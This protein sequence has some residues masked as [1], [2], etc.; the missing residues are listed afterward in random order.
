MSDIARRIDEIIFLGL[1]ALLKGRGFK[2]S[3][4]NF[5]KQQNGTYQVLNIQA[6]MFN[7]SDEGRFTVNLGIFFPEIN[8]LVGIF[9]VS[10]VPK[11]TEC[12]VRQR[13]GLL[14][15]EGTDFWWKVEPTSSAQEV[16]RHLRS[17]VETFGLP[18]LEKNSDVRAAGPLLRKQ[19]PF[20]AAATALYEGNRE[21]A[22]AT[23]ESIIAKGSAAASRAR[24]WGK[25]HHLI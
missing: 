6:S 25:R 18:W 4:R 22:K 16:A 7:D 2:K 3:G 19:N 15:P 23:I 14:A 8:D 11:E 20:V 10:G 9:E 24:H 5:Y 12:T 1:K 21:E 17:F 13:I